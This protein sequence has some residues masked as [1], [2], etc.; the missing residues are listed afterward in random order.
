MIL[1]PLVFPGLSNTRNA[2][3]RPVQHRQYQNSI[4]NARKLEEGQNIV[5]SN[6]INSITTFYISLSLSF[7]LSLPLSHSFSLTLFL[8]LPPS[9]S[10]SL[11]LPL[12]H[13]LSP[14]LFL[15]LSDQ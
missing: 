3:V 7:S 10:L 1:P 13:S 15:S 2:S 6:E 9:F 5:K 4:D 14:S 11:S 8:S 12:S